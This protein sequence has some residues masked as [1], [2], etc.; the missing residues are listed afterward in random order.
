MMIPDDV[1]YIIE[2][3]NQEGYEAFVVGGSVR[4]LLLKKTPK[5]WD[6]TTSAKPPAVIRIFEKVIETGIQ[7]GTVTVIVNN[8]NYEV[9][10]YRIDGEYLDSR[11]P[12]QVFFT[13]N[14][15]EDLTRRDFTINAIAYHPKTGF[16]DYFDGMQDISK[17][18]IRAVGK[19]DKRFEEDALRMLRAIRFS[20]QLGFEIEAETFSSLIKNA[21]L[22]KNIS[23]ERIRDELLKTFSADYIEKAAYF[24]KCPV[25]SYALPSWD[26]YFKENLNRIILDLRKLR[27]FLKEPKKSQILAVVLKE[28]PYEQVV[29]LL[30]YLKLDNKTIKT[31]SVY[32]KLMNEKMPDNSYEIKKIISQTGIELFTGLMEIKEGLGET[33]L[34]A[35]VLAEKIILN[36]EPLNIK[37]LK[38]DGNVLGKIGIRGKDIGLC[39]NYLLD[40]VLKEPCVNEEKNLQAMAVVWQNTQI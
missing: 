12:S 22:L 25:I 26:N 40:E 36:K 27:S 31:V 4:D 17:G 37:D 1:I 16:V 2:K 9:T 13:E 21:Y 8:E 33:L 3:L 34:K 6:I 19:A 5:D 29:A 39:L 7:H 23:V 28:M 14:L 35:K 10:T 32:R 20:V 11:R 30:S 38:I 15:K 18:I 24:G